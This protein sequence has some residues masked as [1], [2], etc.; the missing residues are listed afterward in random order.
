M[1]TCRR[2]GFVLLFALGIVAVVGV[3]ILALAS[4]QSYDGRRTVERIRET[5]L[6]QMLLAGAMEAPSHLGEVQPTNDQAWNVQL[7]AGLTSR[8]GTLQT[9][10]TSVQSD[11]NCAIVIRATLEGKSLQQSVTFARQGN[12]WKLTSAR[13]DAD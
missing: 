3:A 13:L 6:E 7:P 11:T 8:G 5:Q 2:G 4:L 12:Q 1:I 10:I 9:R